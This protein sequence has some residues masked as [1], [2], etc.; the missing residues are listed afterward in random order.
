MLNAALEA[1]QETDG[2]STAEQWRDMCSSKQA[3][4]V[5]QCVQYTCCNDFDVYTSTHNLVQML[6]QMLH[7]AL[8]Y[9]V[10]SSLAPARL[11]QAHQVTTCVA[12]SSVP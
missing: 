8:A 2:A 9:A 12:S 7:S 4:A 3:A 1:L 10:G 11:M 6:Q 5:A